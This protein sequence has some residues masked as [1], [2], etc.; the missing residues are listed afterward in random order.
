LA[1]PESGDELQDLAETLNGMLGRIENAFRHVTQFTANAS[2]ELRAPLALIRA[3]SEVALLRVS[4]NVDTYREALHRIL[5][6]TEKNS[7][8][9][10]D[11]LRLARADASTIALALKPL[12]FG[13]HIDRLCER[14]LPL[15]VEKNIKLEQRGAP[16]DFWIL[17]DADHLKRLW[18]ILLDN[19]IKYTPAG[20]SIVVSWHAAPSGQMICEVRDTGIGISQSDLPHIFE[21]FYRADKARSREEGGAGLGLA[22]AR[23][24]VDAHR[25]SIEVE[26]HPGQGT[27]IRVALPLLGPREKPDAAGNTSAHP[28][29]DDVP[30]QI[31]LDAEA[32]DL[33]ST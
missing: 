24:I 7:A 14:V 23:W 15:A 13:P 9:L 11:M 5:R 28:A 29:A 30:E 21:R 18:L 32:S 10:D 19:A 22:I 16:G 26:S 31:S 2:H 3:T 27:I 1:V 17:A 4:G 8:L 33:V 25:A 20:G 6:E 12:E